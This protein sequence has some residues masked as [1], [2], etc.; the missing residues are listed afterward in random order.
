MILHAPGDRAVDRDLGRLHVGMRVRRQHG[1]AGRQRLDLVEM[2]R[3]GVE[4]GALAGDTS[5]GR[6]PAGVSAMRRP[7]PIS[8]PFGFGRTTPPA[9]TVM[10]CR[11]Q[12]LPNSGVLL[13]RTS[14]ASSICGSIDGPPS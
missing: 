4:H 11:P 8:R 7:M 9:A 13:L 2:H 5:D 3:D 1:G 12:Q 10:T 14:R 6:G